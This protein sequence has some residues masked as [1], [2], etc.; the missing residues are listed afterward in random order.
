MARNEELRA[1]CLV[2][3]WA[4]L[5]GCALYVRVCAREREGV[6]ISIHLSSM[7]HTNHMRYIDL[8]RVG[9]RWGWWDGMEGK[10]NEAGGRGKGIGGAVG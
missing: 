1:Y 8:E 10:G 6:Y 3:V 2:L 4:R 5:H 7:L 9:V